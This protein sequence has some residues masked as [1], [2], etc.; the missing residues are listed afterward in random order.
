MPKKSTNLGNGTDR[1]GDVKENLAF[2]SVG[3]FGLPRQFLTDTLTF[4]NFTLDGSINC[5]II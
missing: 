5:P 3:Q 4:A 1:S 2:P